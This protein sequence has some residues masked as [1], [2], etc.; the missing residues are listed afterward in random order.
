MQPSNRPQP[1][2]AELVRDMTFGG[3]GPRPGRPTPPAGAAFWAPADIPSAQT[4]GRIGCDQGH[5]TLVAAVADR[6]W[7][8]NKLRETALVSRGW[9]APYPDFQYATV[10]CPACSTLWPG[11]GA[12]TLHSARL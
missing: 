12:W 3:R 7:A 1:M 10:I 4:R 6:V 5:W 11:T 2:L 9:A 8:G